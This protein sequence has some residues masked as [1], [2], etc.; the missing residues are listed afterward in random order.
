[1]SLDTLAMAFALI[2]G[3]ASLALLVAGATAAIIARTVKSE[4]GGL[5]TDITKEFGLLRGEM[6]VLH[7]DTVALRTDMTNELAALRRD[8]TGELLALRKDTA[9]GFAAVHQRIDQTNE[10]IGQPVKS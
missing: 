10:H 3:V 9:N 5:R 2:L 1:M 8:M 4:L 7:T 6:S